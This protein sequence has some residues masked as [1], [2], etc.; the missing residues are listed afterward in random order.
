MRRKATHVYSDFHNPD[1]APFTL[2]PLAIEDFT[3]TP[4]FNLTPEGR[5][6]IPPEP[7]TLSSENV[8]ACLEEFF[9]AFQERQKARG[10]AAVVASMHIEERTA[11]TLGWAILSELGLLS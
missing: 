1:S 3:D 9:L 4:V 10:N 5:A 7:L 6:A 8:K 2:S 11:L